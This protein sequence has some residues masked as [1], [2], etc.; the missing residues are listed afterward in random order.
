MQQAESVCQRAEAE[1]GRLVLGCVNDG[2][3]AMLGESARECAAGVATVERWKYISGPSARLSPP[4]R[5]RV[6][7]GGHKPRDKAQVAVHVDRADADV[8]SGLRHPGRLAE[9]ASGICDVLEHEVSQ[10]QVDARVV[11]RPR[12][13]GIDE[14]KLV[15]EPILGRRRI[16]IDSDHPPA[17]AT[18]DAQIPPHPHRVVTLS[19]ASASDV[20]RDAVGGQQLADSCVEPHRAVELGEPAE[21]LLGMKAPSR[22]ARTPLCTLVLARHAARV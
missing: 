4:Q 6:K 20:E 1:V 15:D 7:S 12:L 8:A 22:V 17:V 13:I 19:A 16:H 11:H 14:P 3:E 5:G 18:E 9:E 2:V 10:C 21:L